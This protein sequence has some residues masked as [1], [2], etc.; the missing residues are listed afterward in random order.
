MGKIPRKHKRFKKYQ[1]HLSKGQSQSLQNYCQ[2]NNIS[3]NKL[4]KKV[5]KTYISDFSDEKLGKVYAD[6]KQLS[7]FYEREMDYEQL[8]I[9]SSNHL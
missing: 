4:I 1:F 8:D 6:K 2:M 9:F 3:A 5:L 7:L